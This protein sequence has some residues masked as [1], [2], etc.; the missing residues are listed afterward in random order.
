M[1]V[2][3]RDLQ[4]PSIRFATSF[5]LSSAKKPVQKQILFFLQPKQANLSLSPREFERFV[6]VS[7]YIQCD[8]GT[9]RAVLFRGSHLPNQRSF[10]TPPTERSREMNYPS[11][12]RFYSFALIHSHHSM[13]TG[14]GRGP[15]SATCVVGRKIKILKRILSTDVLRAKKAKIK[16]LRRGV[17]IL[18]SNDVVS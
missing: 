13:S 14:E 2:N 4:S 15:S 8:V 12:S 17:L 5:S 3:R 10:I 16:H 11:R 1:N 7:A 18:T 9:G 6:G